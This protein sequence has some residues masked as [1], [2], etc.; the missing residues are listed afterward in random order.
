M[1]EKIYLYPVWVRLWHMYNALLMLTL[2]FTGL[3]LQYSWCNWLTIRFDVVI[4]IHNVSGI[5][6]TAGFLFYLI[7]NHFTP[8]EIYYHSDMAGRFRR[9]IKQFRYYSY[10]IFKKE[11]PPFPI[12]RER[13][14]NP[15]QKLSYLFV[16]YIIV[17]IIIVSG[18]GL[19]FPEILP[20]KIFNISGILI[21]DLVHITSGFILSVFMVVHIYFCT[22]GKTPVSNFTSMINGWH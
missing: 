14:F 21:T 5:A 20:V 4:L 18:F 15:L 1:K 6:L 7:G 17:P 12:S 11:D 2:I 9:V 19:L 10:G 3:C 22:I 13:K 8:N 16:M